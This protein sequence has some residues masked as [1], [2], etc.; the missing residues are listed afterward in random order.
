MIMRNILFVILLFFISHTVYAQN[1][2]EQQCAYNGVDLNQAINFVSNLQAALKNNDKEK[3]AGFIA[4][5]LRVNMALQ[6]GK[7]TTRYIKN[8]K[9]FIK[10]YDSLFDARAR[11]SLLDENEIFCNYQGAMLSNGLVWF[12]TD[13]N[14][15]RI[16]ALNINRD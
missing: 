12:K 9:N 13:D 8:K 4:Y 11:Q 7:S 2:T 6:N 10:N 5:P 16:I 14:K 15:V 1:S 3:I